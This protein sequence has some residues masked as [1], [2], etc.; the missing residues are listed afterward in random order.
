M[1]ITRSIASLCGM[2]STMTRFS[3]ALLLPV[4]A[5]LGIVAGCDQASGSS[6]PAAPTQK[7]APTGDELEHTGK[8]GESK[9]A[10]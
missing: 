6:N 5:V 10:T 1:A 3:A 2:T 7:G 4:V 9:P 8:P